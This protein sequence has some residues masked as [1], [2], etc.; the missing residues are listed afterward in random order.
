MSLLDWA[1]RI[2]RPITEEVPPPLEELLLPSAEERRSALENVSS[3]IR[4]RERVL[5]MLEAKANVRGGDFDGD[6]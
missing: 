2:M 3:T 6:T 1:K 4:H 5:R